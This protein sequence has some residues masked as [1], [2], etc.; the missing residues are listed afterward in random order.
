MTT[1][2]IHDISPADTNW[3][4]GYAH[5]AYLRAGLLRTLAKTIEVRFV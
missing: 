3:D 5:L 1:K 4:K 2:L